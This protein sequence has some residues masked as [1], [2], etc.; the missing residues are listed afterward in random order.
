MAI[1]AVASQNRVLMVDNKIHYYFEVSAPGHSPAE[2]HY[3]ANPGTSWTTI[4]LAVA[5]QAKA[6]A[7]SEWNIS[8]GLLDSVDCYFLA[9]GL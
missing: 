1:K 8:F 4:K 7:E 3:E 2:L 5:T 6:Y 9:S